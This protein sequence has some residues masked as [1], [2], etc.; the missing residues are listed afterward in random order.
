MAGLS[1]QQLGI[2]RQLVMLA[3]ARG[4]TPQQAREFAAAAYSESGLNP[5]ARNSS[6]GAAG[7][8]QL[9][10]S[11]YRQ[12]AM[13]LG[14]LNNV[15]ANALAIL[16]EYLSYWRQHPNAI[17]GEAGASVEAS[18]QGAGFYSK[19]LD[20][21]PQV[22]P[23]VPMPGAMHPEIRNMIIRQTHPDLHEEALAG[24][25]AI[26]HGSFDP[27]ARLDALVEARR[28]S[29]ALSAPQSGMSGGQVSTPPAQ[30]GVPAQGG[31]PRMDQHGGPIAP[32]LISAP[33]ADTTHVDT[34]LL[35]SLEAFSHAIGK[36]VTIISGYR[37]PAYSAK[38]GGYSSDP[39]TR[40]VAVDAY[41]DGVPIGDYPGAY[42]WLTAH[43]L[44]SGAQPNFYN[45]KPDPEHVQIPGSGV[46]KSI[47]A[48][49]I[50]GS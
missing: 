4:A 27:I 3:H 41:I 14:G 46:N 20:L 7:L 24:L 19:G 2:A 17:P 15:R 1:P 35:Q 16:P 42:K 47:R 9:L 30:P 36:P 50:R 48:R 22:G 23:G 33:Q 34:R 39:H 40:G 38:V 5:M 6:S 43:G 44:E 25:Q 31:Y 28:A 29:A 10:S 13:Q 8:F 12:R 37:S 26:A 32:G 18:G 45:G 21:M 49:R 11:G